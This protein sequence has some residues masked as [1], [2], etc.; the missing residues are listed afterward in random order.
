MMQELQSTAHAAL[1]TVRDEAQGREAELIKLHEDQIT[2]LQARAPP[3]FGAG[4]RSLE[5]AKAENERLKSDRMD[6]DQD[7][8]TKQGKV[9]YLKKRAVEA[10]KCRR[11]RSRSE[12]RSYR[13]SGR[14][15]DDNEDAY[16]F[17]DRTSQDRESGRKCLFATRSPSP[18]R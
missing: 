13:S 6:I 14:P 5:D 18:R 8:A 7:I 2:E 11:S 16:S 15:D 17:S 3:T 1:N 10:S 9:E 12:R 4:D